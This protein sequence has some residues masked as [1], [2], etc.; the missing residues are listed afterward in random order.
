[1]CTFCTLIEIA[2]QC[3]PRLR[4]SDDDD[5]NDSTKDGGR[6]CPPKSDS[7]RGEGPS[8]FCCILVKALAV[9][10]GRCCGRC[11]EADASFGRVTVVLPRLS[12]L[13][14]VQYGDRIVQ[15]PR[16]PTIV[17][18]PS[19]NSL[20][21][22]RT[23]RPVTRRRV[24]AHA[25]LSGVCVCVCVCARAV[26]RVHAC[27][28]SPCGGVHTL[29]LLCVACV[30]MRAAPCTCLCARVGARRHRAIVCTWRVCSL[31]ARP[32]RFCGSPPPPP[33]AHTHIP[34]TPI[35]IRTH[36]P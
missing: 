10:G 33:D 34:H 16:V 2:R 36:P 4:A 20:V 21:F 3:G 8:Y 32:S 30:R 27:L 26:C 35:R 17:Y 19:V 13:L 25:E 12:A 15:H 31:R 14:T 29:R 24:T 9:Q 6:N 18:H 5:V 22:F 23:C 11:N 1:M 28:R 7:R